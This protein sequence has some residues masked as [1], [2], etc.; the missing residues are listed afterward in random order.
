V[1]ERQIVELAVRHRLLT[2]FTAFVVVDESET[3]VAGDSRTVVQPVAMPQGWA[4]GSALGGAPKAAGFA[5][6]EEMEGPAMYDLAEPELDLDDTAV[7]M[8]P[9]S[10]PARA[11]A[12]SQAFRPAAFTAP[13]P[14][15]EPEIDLL[16]ELG[17]EPAPAEQAPAVGEALQALAEAIE[18]AR[19]ELAAGRVPPPA[20][21]VAA[22]TRLLAALAAWRG[23]VDV[24][25]LQRFLRVALA[26]A[27]AACGASGATAG[28]LMPLLTSR[29]D[30]FAAAHQEAIVALSSTEGPRWG[31]TL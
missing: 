2:R 21:L 3:V 17:E 7:G 25:A 20:P 9:P 11:P 14:P 19:R 29:F 15:E 1:I 28:S 27:I 10:L 16:G 4:A 18:E 6:F 8:A 13:P 31:L 5:A 26:E 12:P 22:R 30:A 24:P 23:S